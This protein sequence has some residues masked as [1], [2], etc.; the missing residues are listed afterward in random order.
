MNET[1][2]GA[3][4]S[5]F[6]IYVAVGILFA[7]PFV[8]RGVH[9]ID[10]VARKGTW[11]FR[12]IVLPG[13]VALWPLLLRRVMVASPPPEECNAHRAAAARHHT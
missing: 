11:G 12:L 9:R 7:V 2:A 1:L 10:P 6:G 4:V 8:I 5:I 3:I 13:V